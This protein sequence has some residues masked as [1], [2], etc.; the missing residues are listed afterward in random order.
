MYTYLSSI[1]T[2]AG[3]AHKISL[4]RY[5]DYAIW[6]NSF[7]SCKPRNLKLAGQADVSY[8]NS[9]KVDTLLRAAHLARDTKTLRY[10]AHPATGQ[11]C[12][13]LSASTE[14]IKPLVVD[15]R[16]YETTISASRNHNV[17]D[18]I[19]ANGGDRIAVTCGDSCRHR[20]LPSLFD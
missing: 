8:T 18:I 13:A 7:G 9:Q 2:V 14:V 16:P 4:T 5:C 15:K 6:H 17:P 10:V 1:F 20:R 19:Q 12:I 11:C 3:I